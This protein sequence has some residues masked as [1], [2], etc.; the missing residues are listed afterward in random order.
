[1]SYNSTLTLF[2]KM[3]PLSQGLFFNP[4]FEDSLNHSQRSN[5]SLLSRS[6]TDRSLLPSTIPLPLS[7][8]PYLVLDDT[9][10]MTVTDTETPPPW[11]DAESPTGLP[12]SSF[13]VD[14]P[15]ELSVDQAVASTKAPEDW[16]RGSPQL[17]RK[18]T[19]PASVLPWPASSLRALTLTTDAAAAT[20]KKMV[21]G[22]Y[23]DDRLAIPSSGVL[24][25]GWSR[26]VRIYKA[27]LLKRFCY[28][29]R[30]RR[31]IVSQVWGA[32]SKFYS[33]WL[34]AFVIACLSFFLISF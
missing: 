3:T 8:L 29:S 21:Q 18:S 19:D 2:F 23:F 10:S 25:M 32:H 14:H 30:D 26:T 7:T 22:S 33:L 34:F 9:S 4:T 16:T 28:A 1:M 15:T 13:C 31:A 17:T 27:L 24:L 12:A 5:R 11:L 6:S 20:V